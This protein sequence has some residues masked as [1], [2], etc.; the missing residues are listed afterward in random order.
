M[1]KRSQELENSMAMEE[2]VNDAAAYFRS[3]MTN[4]QRSLFDD[5][6]SLYRDLEADDSGTL[7]AVGLKAFNETLAR[8]QHMTKDQIGLVIGR[9]Q[10]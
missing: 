6:I 4:D 2:A 3:I 8:V 5:L 7:T 1:S 9:K 10:P